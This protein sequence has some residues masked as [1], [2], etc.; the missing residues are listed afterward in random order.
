MKRFVPVIVILVWLGAFRLLGST[1]P[2][3]EVTSTV[4]DTVTTMCGKCMGKGRLPCQD[5]G[6]IGYLRS[7]PPC[8]KCRG[9]GNM[10]W[11][12]Q[13]ASKAGIAASLAKCTACGGSGENRNHEPRRTPC[14]TCDK[15]GR[16]KCTKCGG[17]GQIKA[18][19][20]RTI[21][22]V[23]AEYSAWE[24]FIATLWI[25]PN[26]N[27]APQKVKG[28]IPLAEQFVKLHA[29]E[30]KVKLVS[31]ERV[32]KSGP[33]WH[34]PVVLEGLT[35]GEKKQVVFVVHNRQIIDTLEK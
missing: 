11:K 28:T 9:S 15:L 24:R 2:V 3:V 22:T 32:R 21:H 10:K 27:C 30:Q 1:Q 26:Q 8:P 14:K 35:S 29:D 12:L 16:I 20:I 13:D 25:E 6:G 18:T 23:R 33:N 5:C 19:N 34:I 17:S 4:S 7:Y 31:V